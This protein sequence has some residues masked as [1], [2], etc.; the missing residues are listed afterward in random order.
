MSDPV[1]ID[2]HAARAVG[3]LSHDYKKENILKL[4]EDVI[5]PEVQEAELMMFSLIA[6]RLVDSATNAQLD[7]WGKVVG[8]PRDGLSDIAYRGF[9]NARILSNL[10]EG[11]TET[12]IEVLSILTGGDVQFRATYPAAFIANYEVS[13]FTSASLS[14]RVRRQIES[15]TPSGVGVHV[16]ESLVDGFGFLEDPTA[17]GF[18]DGTFSSVI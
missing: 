5:M 18:D 11:Q 3:N 2:D 15:I 17:L 16:V 9:I 14:D 4:L 7:Q 10:S 6:E 13:G 8:E 1:L 12:I